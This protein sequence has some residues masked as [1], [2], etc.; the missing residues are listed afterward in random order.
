MCVFFGDFGG[1]I[2]RLDRSGTMDASAKTL[3]ADTESVSKVM[4]TASYLI[5]LNQMTLA[6]MELLLDNR[7]IPIQLMKER[8]LESFMRKMRI[9]LGKECTQQNFSPFLLSIPLSSS[10]SALCL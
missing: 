6:L 5:F 3:F 7:E 1:E 2:S 4:K 10:R 8:T 9:P